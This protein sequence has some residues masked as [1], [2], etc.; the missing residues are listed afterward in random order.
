MYIE[1]Y[2][3]LRPPWSEEIIARSQPDLLL[4][5]IQHAYFIMPQS[6]A[7]TARGFQKIP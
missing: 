1:D 5:N 3:P 7:S 4:R 2:I 6:Y